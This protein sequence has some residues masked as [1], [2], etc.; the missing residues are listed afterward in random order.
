[1]KSILFDI[2][3]ISQLVVDEQNRITDINHNALEMIG[4]TKDELTA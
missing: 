3:P 2:H 1:M 4:M